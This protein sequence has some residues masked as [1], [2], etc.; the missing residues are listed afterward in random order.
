[1]GSAIETNVSNARDIWPDWIDIYK[2]VTGTVKSW[3]VRFSDDTTNSLHFDTDALKDA[4]QTLTA[5]DTYTGVSLRVGFKYGIFTD[6]VSHTNGSDTNIVHGLGSAQVGIIKRVDAAGDWWITHPSLSTN[7]N[8]KI[9]PSP[10]EAETITQYVGVDSTNITIKSAAPTG[11]YRVIALRQVDGFSF[12]GDHTGNNSVDGTY[13]YS[14]VRPFFGLYKNKDDI[15]NWLFFSKDRLGYNV[16]NNEL[17]PNT[18]DVEGTTDFLD[19][20]SNG[21]KIRSTNVEL[22]ANSEKY[23]SIEFGQPNKWSN[24]R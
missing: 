3:E 7:Y 11:T 23:I 5:G 9:N 1:M 21:R 17:H 20:L 2:N 16:D 24:A 15:D 19:F 8:I 4:K 18:N 14:G 22:N 10:A 12:F 6:E 13:A